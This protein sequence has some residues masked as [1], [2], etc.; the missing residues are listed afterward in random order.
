M[1]DKT[2]QQQKHKHL[3]TTLLE[4]TCIIPVTSQL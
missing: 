2:E 1:K 3:F 4:L